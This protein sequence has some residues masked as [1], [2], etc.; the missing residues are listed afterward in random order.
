MPR[1]RRNRIKQAHAASEIA[2]A[3]SEIKYRGAEGLHIS[4]VGSAISG[5]PRVDV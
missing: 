1:I 3:A 5:R 2:H 4:E